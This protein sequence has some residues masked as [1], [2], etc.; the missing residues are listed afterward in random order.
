MVALAVTSGIGTA[1]AEAQTLA[2]ADR[3]SSRTYTRAELL[4]HPATREVSIAADPVRSRPLRV[5]LHGLPPIQRGGR[6]PARSRS[7]QADEPARVFP[8]GG[9]Q[10]IAAQSGVCADLARAQNAGVRRRHPERSR[11]RRHR[12]V[13]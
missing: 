10:E 9:V 3:M 5:G 4:A 8:A 12:G 13:A 7:R 1:M 11:Y 2:V 6:R